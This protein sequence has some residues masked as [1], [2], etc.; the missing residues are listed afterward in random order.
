VFGVSR[1]SGQAVDA[2]TLRES[3]LRSPLG[4]ML[5]V[6][7]GGTICALEFLDQKDRVHKL[8]R[9]RYGNF[10]L[11]KARDPETYCAR[12]Q[13][14]FDGALDA[15]DHLPVDG[16]GTPFQRRVWSALRAIPAGTTLSYSALAACLGMP[17][18][19][20]AVAGANALNPVSIIVPCHRVIGADG[21]LRGYAGGLQRKRWLL[22][23]EGAM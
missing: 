18:A 4:E 6:S 1:A 5:L 19:V 23:H 21:A 16:G 15:I 10:N 20:R 9:R 12:V 7:E 2:I 22:Q 8:L 11:M 13:A 14:Y 17:K 3:H